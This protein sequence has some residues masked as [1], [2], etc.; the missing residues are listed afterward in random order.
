VI[1]DGT[2]IRGPLDLRAD[3][4]V[5]GTGIGGSVVARE[6][7]A[8]GLAVIALEEG[9]DGRPV[10]SELMA[11][12]HRL[13]Q[14]GWQAT[15]DRGVEVQQALLLGGSSRLG[16]GLARRAPT[17]IFEEQADDGVASLGSAALDAAYDRV[18]A[19]D[20]PVPVTDGVS[21]IEQAAGSLGYTSLR[22][23]GLVDE[24]PRCWLGTAAS[25]G[26]T[27]RRIWTTLADQGGIRLL[28]S[29][30]AED[31]EVAADGGFVVEAATL[32]RGTVRFPV[33][34]EAGALVLAAG[35]VHSPALALRSRLPDPHRLLGQG[36]RLQPTAPLI[37]RFDGSI[38]PA[39]EVRLELELPG[40]DEFPDA[41]ARTTAMLPG[42]LARYL[43]LRDQELAAA[44]A[45][46]SHLRVLTVTLRDRRAGRVVPMTDTHP[47][48][49][50]ELAP[51]D[52]RRLRAAMTE[53]ARLLLAAG[54]RRVWTSHAVP[55]EICAESEL[56]RIAD[57]H[58]RAAD[59]GLFSTTPLGTCALAA[60]PRD[61]VTGDGGRF[62][63]VEGLYVA[64]ASLLPAAPGVPTGHT[65]AAL[66]LGVAEAVRTDRGAAG[67]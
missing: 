48:I 5:V 13:R 55:T 57:R 22:L 50:Y 20:P 36:L 39:A 43:P 34:I 14:R 27:V 17:G 61:G 65:V 37:A 53:G 44:M 64:D 24:D 45:D 31:I 9:A 59:L 46:R 8:A 47:V 52:R 26:R 38:D 18:E 23:P 56:G 11:R 7:E 33:R 62:H 2:D 3:V 15:A 4:C 54:A 25:S 58:Y 49:R 35:A 60:R 41:R 12:E 16:P 66:A 28:T 67:A 6:L 29:C 10:D 30:R 42:Q 19:G 40:G 63:G 51:S 32:E 1:L 21:A